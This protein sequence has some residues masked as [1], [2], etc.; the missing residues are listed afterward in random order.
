MKIDEGLA[1]QLGTPRGASLSTEEKAQIRPL[2]DAGISSQAIGMK[3]G[4][5][6]C[7][8]PTYLR[9]SDG[10]NK[11]KDVRRQNVSHLMTI[12]RSAGKRP[13]VAS[14]STR[15]EQN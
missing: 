9:D 13:T 3:T 6:H 12:G 5:T 2:N 1:Y 11:K 15:S 10:C 7:F 8:V 14:C 4:R